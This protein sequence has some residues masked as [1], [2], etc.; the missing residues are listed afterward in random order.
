VCLALD[1]HLSDRSCS[2]CA[3]HESQ[4]LILWQRVGIAIGRGPQMDEDALRG[5]ACAFRNRRLVKAQTLEYALDDSPDN[6][7]APRARWS[8]TIWHEITQL[9]LR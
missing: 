6:D 4:E 5:V 9:L 1:V 3:R 7:E 2:K 8:E